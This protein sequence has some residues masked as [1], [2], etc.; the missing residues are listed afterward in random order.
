MQGVEYGSV[1][2]CTYQEVRWRPVARSLPGPPVGVSSSPPPPEEQSSSLEWVLGFG[3][4][5]LVVLLFRD[6]LSVESA[7]SVV[8]AVTT[9]GVSGAVV[10]VAAV[11]VA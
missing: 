11:R 4:S 2:G 3:F 7:P 1:S 9:V 6:P 5:F 10:V 8:V